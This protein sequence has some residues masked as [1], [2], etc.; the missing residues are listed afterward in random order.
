MK[1]KTFIKNINKF[2]FSIFPN[3]S[4]ACPCFLLSDHYGSAKFRR[5]KATRRNHMRGIINIQLRP[6]S[7]PPLHFNCM[8]RLRGRFNHLGR[9]SE[10]HLW[11]VCNAG[12][13]RQSGAVHAFPQIG[14]PGLAS[15]AGPR[16]PLSPYPPGPVRPR[17]PG[18]SACRDSSLSC[19]RDNVCVGD[20]EVL[21][22]H[23]TPSSLGS[24]RGTSSCT[25]CGHTST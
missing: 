7:H 18:Q 1:N 14:T 11:Q 4:L 20:S 23:S 16:P 6:S 10:T 13:R 19:V 21:G 24:S 17:L 8:N 3:E 12:G 2:C 5:P 22:R 9:G 15:T 25:S